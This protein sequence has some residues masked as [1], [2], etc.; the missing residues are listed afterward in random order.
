MFILL[1][2]VKSDLQSLKKEWKSLTKY[3]CATSALYFKCSEEIWLSFGEK[4]TKIWFNHENNEHIDL[5]LHGLNFSFLIFFSILDKN[6]LLAL[7]NYRQ[8]TVYRMGSLFQ[9]INC[10]LDPDLIEHLHPLIQW[11]FSSVRSPSDLCMYSLTVLVQS[12]LL[13]VH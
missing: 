1:M 3:S 13:G 7:K 2:A 12:K 5:T 10:T 4:Q 11:K 8:F 9:N 6:T